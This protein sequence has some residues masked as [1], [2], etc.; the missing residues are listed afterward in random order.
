MPVYLN[1]L[2]TRFLSK[3]GRIIRG[4]V[5]HISEIAESGVYSFLSHEEKK[6]VKSVQPPAAIIVCVG[7]GARFLGGVEDKDVYP[8]RGQTVLVNAP[9]IKHGKT[10]SDLDAE[11]WTYMIPRKTGTVILG[12]TLEPNDW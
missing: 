10:L 8:I 6:H 7:L 9:W 3:G 11:T 1:Y 2:S 5:Q 4:S 12:G